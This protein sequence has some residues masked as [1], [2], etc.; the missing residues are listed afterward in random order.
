MKDAFLSRHTKLAACIIFGVMPEE[1][2]GSTKRSARHWDARHAVAH[3][4]RNNHK[5]RLLQI[6]NTLNR[7]HTTV[8]HGARRCLERMKD[9]PGYKR[10]VERMIILQELMS[11]ADIPTVHEFTMRQLSEI[12]DMRERRQ[13]RL[14]QKVASA[15]YLEKLSHEERA[16]LYRWMDRDCLPRRIGMRMIRANRRFAAAMEQA[17]FEQRAA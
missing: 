8:L 1:L 9:E 5:T 16:Q 11:V 6:A 14:R 7:D 2:T 3:H 4:L 10:N 12:V 15:Q 17:Q 13:K